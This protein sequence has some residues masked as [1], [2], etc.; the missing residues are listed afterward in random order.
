MSAPAANDSPPP[1]EN[2]TETTGRVVLLYEMEARAEAALGARKVT[3]V[4]AASDRPNPASV[5]INV[6][7]EGSHTLGVI[8]TVTM[9]SRAPMSGA[10][11]AKLGCPSPSVD[12]MAEMDADVL[13]TM[14]LPLLLTSAAV[15]LLM[16][17]RELWG[18]DMDV[19]DEKDSALPA[20]ISATKETLITNMPLLLL[21]TR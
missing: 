9:M 17:G 2:T 18:F 15:M 6:P 12:A 8:V 5:T 10:D 13:L 3:A 1:L 7:L 20:G 19:M 14:T 4:L 11:K 16:N 21:P